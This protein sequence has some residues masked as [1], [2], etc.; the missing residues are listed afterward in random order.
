IPEI[1]QSSSEL[2]AESEAGET[3]ALPG[4][5]QDAIPEM[6]Q[7]SSEL[8]AESV[9]A[10]DTGADSETSRSESGTRSDSEEGPVVPK[11]DTGSNPEMKPVLPHLEAKPVFSASDL[12]GP[13]KYLRYPTRTSILVEL[14]GLSMALAAWLPI[15]TLPGLIILFKWE[16]ADLEAFRISQFGDEYVKYKSRSWYLVPYVY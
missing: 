4:T 3:P 1:E 13:W 5:N 12:S 15:F 10:A 2:Q 14:I 9:P 6:E 16:L 11:S 7:S 8:R